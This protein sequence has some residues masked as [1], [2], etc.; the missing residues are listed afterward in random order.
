MGEGRVQLP[1][2]TAPPLKS[3]PLPTATGS[4]TLSLEYGA[5]HDCDPS[6][7]RWQ[8]MFG[9]LIGATSSIAGADSS[10]LGMAAWTIVFEGV[11][12]GEDIEL[13]ALQ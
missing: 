9:R 11:F 5:V 4:F 7:M 3:K 13:G 12:E 6:L 2:S 8:M 1:C 10:V